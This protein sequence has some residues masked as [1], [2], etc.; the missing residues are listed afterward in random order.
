M[1]DGPDWFDVL[2][3]FEKTNNRTAQSFHFRNTIVRG[4]R[5]AL[6][7]PICG[8]TKQSSAN[9]RQMLLMIKHNK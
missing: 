9:V 1:A 5:V 2:T 3:I 6:T 4:K 7:K 8:Y